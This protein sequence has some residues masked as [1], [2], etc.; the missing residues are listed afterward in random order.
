MPGRDDPGVDRK[1]GWPL[2][3]EALPD[4][5]QRLSMT[6]R[7]DADG[8]REDLRVAKAA[9]DGETTLAPVPP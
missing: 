8:V 6:V 2:A 1:I 7:W 5:M 3:G 4:R 9:P